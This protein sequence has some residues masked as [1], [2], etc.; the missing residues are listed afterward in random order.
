M[1]TCTWFII[2]HY[3]Y[4][5]NV[6]PVWRTFPNNAGGYTTVTTK[7]KNQPTIIFLLY[8]N[9]V[10]L[11]KLLRL[12][13]C[14]YQQHCNTGIRIRVF[15]MYVVM[16]A[17]TIIDGIH[18]LW[19]DFRIVVSDSVIKVL[20]YRLIRFTLILHS[21]FPV[22][23]GGDVLSIQTYK[24]KNILSVLSFFLMYTNMQCRYYTVCY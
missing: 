19:K 24:K 17:V 5:R 23:A 12:R 7:N 4:Y 13:T 20:P 9:Y 8:V 15:I 2:V 18:K 14:R 6:S 16:Y 1:F 11:C 3:P 22:V 21:T 10:F